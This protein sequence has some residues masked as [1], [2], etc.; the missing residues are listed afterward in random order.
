MFREKPLPFL[1]VNASAKKLHNP[2]MDYCVRLHEFFFTKET[3]N[4]KRD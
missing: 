2:K 4:P 1:G 3:K